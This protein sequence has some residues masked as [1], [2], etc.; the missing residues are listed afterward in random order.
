MAYCEMTDL[1]EAFCAHCRKVELP[2]ELLGAS[3]GGEGR[4][5]N[6][7]AAKYPGTCAECGGRFEETD[8]ISRY[9]EGKYAHVRC[10]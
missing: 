3:G 2:P 6:H 8:K 7:F 10:P 4:W 5:G 1:E 9:G